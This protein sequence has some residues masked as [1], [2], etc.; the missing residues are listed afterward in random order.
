MRHR[1]AWLAIAAA[2]LGALAVAP[3]TAQAAP[4]RAERVL[5][6]R[7]AVAA[8]H[9]PSFAEDSFFS[10]TVAAGGQQH[11]IWNNA[12]VNIAYHV[13]FNP[14]GAST[15]TPCRFDLANQW[16]ETLRTGERKF[17]FVIRN[18]GSISCGATIL[19]SAVDAANVGSTGGMVP[20]ETQTFSYRNLDEGRAYL[21]GLVPSG[22]TTT[23]TC[24]FKV[25]SVAYDREVDGDVATPVNMYYT[26][27][28]VGSITC[29]AGIEVGSD[30]VDNVL[31]AVNLAPGASSSRQWNNAN[32]VTAVHLIGVRPDLIGCEI[33]L[34]SQYYRQVI[35]T[36][37]S[38]ERELIFT[39]RNTG[40]IT[41]KGTPVLARI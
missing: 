3:G 36:N 7:A 40:S 32:P 34:I 35:N 24:Q 39:I 27:Q 33:S 13:G 22:A 29:V 20:G 41:C 11:W 8:G 28:N 9:S 14:T 5:D 21:I 37:G 19:L 12:G 38:S 6:A 2:V 18:S 23:S 16:Y 31:S 15:S 10:G 26:V 17:H 4:A 25:T 30:P 1:R